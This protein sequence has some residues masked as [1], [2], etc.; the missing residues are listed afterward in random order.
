MGPVH[1]SP[2]KLSVGRGSTG[3]IFGDVGCRGAVDGV[4]GIFLEVPPADMSASLVTMA[5]TVKAGLGVDAHGATGTKNTGAVAAIEQAQHTKTGNVAAM[6][7]VQLN[8]NRKCCC[9][10]AG[11]A[12]LWVHAGCSHLLWSHV[13][14]WAQVLLMLAPM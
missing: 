10:G 13:V 14:S 3:T 12:L 1:C 7:Q 2:E 11:A 9:Q 5:L 4:L 6:E 8:K